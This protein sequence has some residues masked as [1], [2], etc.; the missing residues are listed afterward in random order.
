MS[1]EAEPV[2]GWYL[3][4]ATNHCV[5]F[6][7]SGEKAKTVLAWG[8]VFTRLFTADELAA[9][10]DDLLAKPNA[11]AWVAEQ[12]AALIAAV[13]DRR[14]RDRERRKAESQADRCEQCDGTGWVS[15]PHPGG[16][17][18]AGTL[19]P[20]LRKPKDDPTGITRLLAVTCACTAGERTAANEQG[21]ERLP[22]SLV[23]YMV[24]Y[25]N[26]AEVEYER[27]QLIEAERSVPSETDYASLA[28]KLA[29]RMN[30]KGNR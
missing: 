18:E 26:W 8:P 15:V 22:L 17:T 14:N 28:A 3:T 10:T 24:R 5:A 12:R 25:P 2:P 7:L 19:R 4:W 30:T 9:A 20:V 1:G 16:G 6:A 29:A 27:R 23:T 13:E 21:R 11:I